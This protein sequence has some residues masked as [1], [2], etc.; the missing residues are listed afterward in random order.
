MIP[1]GTPSGSALTRVTL[2]RNVGASRRTTRPSSRPIRPNWQNKCSDQRR[3]LFSS[4]PL[5]QVLRSH[6]STSK[7]LAPTYKKWQAHAA[8][9]CLRSQN[10]SGRVAQTSLLMSAKV[11][12]ANQPWR[13][14]RCF[15]GGAYIAHFAMC[16]KRRCCH[17]ECNE[18]S[19]HLLREL[20][21]FFAALRMTP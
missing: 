2:L 18:G 6:V 14:G 11:P 12:K 1:R 16:A 8:G 7:G 17:P 5:T 19:R 21:G 10:D 9:K 13:S 4:H 15:A 20:P 3:L